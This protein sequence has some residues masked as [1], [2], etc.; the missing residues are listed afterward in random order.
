MTAFFSAG[1]VLCA[2][3]IAARI[4]L[5][6]RALSATAGVVRLM[7]GMVAKWTVIFLM[8]ALGIGVFHWPA[9]AM[10]T[11]VLTGLAVQCLLLLRFKQ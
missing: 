2:E 1:C 8:A 5:G 7:V 3:W 11:G 10:L 9:V 6:G 4:A